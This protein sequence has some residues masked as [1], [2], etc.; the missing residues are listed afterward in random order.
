[1]AELN[2]APNT[3][4]QGYPIWFTF[5]NKQGG[6]PLLKPASE[7][8]AP[9]S[10]HQDFAWTLSTN[11]MLRSYVPKIVLIE[12]K[13]TQSGQLQSL[14][15]LA[16]ALIETP[17]GTLVASARLNQ[18]VAAA[19]A[20]AATNNINAVAGVFTAAATYVSL[21]ITEPE[22]TK[23]LGDLA[24]GVGNGTS[25]P[26]Y[27]KPYQNLY[28]SQ[29]TG[30][31]YE[32]PYLNIDNM[33]ST[34]GDWKSVDNENTVKNLANL[35]KAVV[36][37]TAEAILGPL[38]GAAETKG[39]MKKI[40][41]SLQAGAAAQQISLASTNPGT[42]VETIKGFIPNSDGDEINI[43]F[44]LYN[45]ESVEDIQKN[46]NFLYNLT[47]QNLPNRRSINLLD[48]PCVYEVEIPGYKKFP[49]AAITKLKITNEGTTRLFDIK[50]GRM[51]DPN[52]ST[53]KDVKM[54]PEAYKVTMTIKSLFM[55]TRNLFYYSYDN[56]D[57]S[58][59]TVTG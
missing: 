45:T 16:R 56:S 35:G 9:I 54:I 42:G 59:I 11:K 21:A 26:N 25:G 48:P 22:I 32:L 51:P 6:A 23:T 50:K 36:G 24:A 49:V 39:I 19:A 15:L 28:P 41:D 18:S 53:G 57:T 10:V 40:S 30:F 52:T 55:N 4:T 14:K 3:G 31:V 46:W 2:K 43:T 44:Y 8:L 20:T 5:D 12:Y 13:L 37:G 7:N 34:G 38:A 33:T 47:Y 1:M 29:P 58:K 27:M 17:I